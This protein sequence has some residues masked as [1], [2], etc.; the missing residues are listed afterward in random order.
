[1]Q[2]PSLSVL[3]KGELVGEYFADLLVEDLL[4]VELKCVEHLAS[5]HTAQCLNYLKASG[6]SVCLLINFQK[7]QVEWKRVVWQF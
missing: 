2:Q 5:Q 1:M 3:Y 4:G 6:K 7:A